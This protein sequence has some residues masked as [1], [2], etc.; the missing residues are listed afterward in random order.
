MDL[1]VNLLDMRLFNFSDIIQNL[2]FS[3]IKLN[4]S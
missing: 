1:M 4:K 2:N 3:F